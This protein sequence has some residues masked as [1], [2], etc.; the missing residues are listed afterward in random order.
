MRIIHNCTVPY[1]PNRRKYS[2]NN[3]HDE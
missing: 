2:N 3:N 1:D